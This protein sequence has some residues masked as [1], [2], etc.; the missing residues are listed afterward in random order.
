VAGNAYPTRMILMTEFSEKTETAIIADM[1]EIRQD[2]WAIVRRVNKCLKLMGR[3]D[4]GNRYTWTDD[5]A[6]VTSDIMMFYKNMAYIMEEKR[7]RF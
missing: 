4:A 6:E 2:A 7:G 5:W 1:K 3:K